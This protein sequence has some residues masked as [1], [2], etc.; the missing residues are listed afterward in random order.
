[1]TRGV[2]VVDYRYLSLL[3]LDSA[4]ASVSFRGITSNG[5]HLLLLEI[6]VGL[7]LPFPVHGAGW[8]TS[9]L[10]DAPEG[11]EGDTDADEGVH[12]DLPALVGGGNGA[13]TVGAEGNPVGS[14][15]LGKRELRPVSLH[16]VS[17]GHPQLSLL[18]GRHPLPSLLNVGKR[19][20]GDRMGG[21]GPPGEGDRS[22]EAGRRSDQSGAQHDSVSRS[23]VVGGGVEMW[24][25]MCNK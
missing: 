8:W 17:E 7:L 20:I 16:S 10:S 2:V 12:D 21:S 11:E 23:G 3:A 5:L 4:R 24:L 13:G 25:V 14:L 6:L 9:E 19:R 1:M 18:L 22:G 15:L